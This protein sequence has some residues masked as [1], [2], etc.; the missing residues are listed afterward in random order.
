MAKQ[1]TPR[2]F[3]QLVGQYL[4]TAESV[5]F[6]DFDLYAN[7][8]NGDS[9]MVTHQLHGEDWE[10]CEETL[11]DRRKKCILRF[12]KDWEE[13]GLTPEEIAETID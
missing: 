12:P 13:K 11:E 10:N 3:Y 2:E 9:I 1:L 8:P 7:Q 5:A 4:K 6:E